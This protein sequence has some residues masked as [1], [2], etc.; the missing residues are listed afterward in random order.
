MRI[1][2]VLLVI[3]NSSSAFSQSTRNSA[4][5][6]HE[7]THVMGS[8]S[9]NVEGMGI[10]KDTTKYRQ[11]KSLSDKQLQEEEVGNNPTS[12][13]TIQGKNSKRIRD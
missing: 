1:F 13:D 5:S 6:G 12:T 4:K 3:I 11:L 10:N 9:E 8:G 2:I 7:S